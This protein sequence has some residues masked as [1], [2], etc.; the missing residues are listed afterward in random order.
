MYRVALN[1]AITLLK[2]S[3]ILFNAID[4]PDPGYDP[5]IE[6]EYSEEISLLYKAISMLNKIEKAMILMWLDEKS[7]EEISTALGISVKNV[8]VKLVRIKKKLV[9]IIE[10]LQ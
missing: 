4:V 3:K 7:Y 8:S 5:G 6:K 1:T 9:E 10:K 2:K